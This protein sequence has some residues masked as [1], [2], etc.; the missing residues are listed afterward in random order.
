MT[1]LRVFSVGAAEGIPAYVYIGLIVTLCIGAILLLWLKGWRKGLRYDMLLLL[2]EWIFLVLGTCVIFR[3]SG[4]E[5]RISLI[6][7]ISYFDYG[8]NS[9]FMEKA[10]LNILNVVLFIPVGILLKPAFCN[11]DNLN[12]KGTMV[13]G[14]LL[15]MAIE[16]L[17]FVFKNGL[18]EIDDVIHNVIGCMTG[19]GLYCILQN[20]HIKPS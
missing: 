10:A 20:L 16:V 1:E 8:E 6:P 2:A 7:L 4:E 12:W 17:Q 18:C 5:C 19:Y 14:L 9:Y 13:V 3:E 11:N 15:S